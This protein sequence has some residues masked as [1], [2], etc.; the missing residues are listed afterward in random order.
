[1]MGLTPCMMT[2]QVQNELDEM[3]RQFDEALATKQMRGMSLAFL[4]VMIATSVI[5]TS[6]TEI[7]VAEDGSDAD[8][9]DGGTA[10]TDLGPILDQLER[11]YDILAELSPRKGQ[12]GS[13]HVG[14]AIN[15]LMAT[16]LAR[17]RKPF[18]GARVE[19]FL[20]KRLLRFALFV[21]QLEVV[22]WRERRSQDRI[23]DRFP[24]HSVV[25]LVLLLGV[26]AV[27]AILKVS[28][29]G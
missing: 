10:D 21:E 28:F 24:D 8:G 15:L 25:Q 14:G 11:L 12:L 1:M 27:F 9:D 20:R 5:G 6:A 3:Q 23:S 17:A 2:W 26:A 4:R 29:G 13:K 16:V 22:G 19:V 18:Y 7:A